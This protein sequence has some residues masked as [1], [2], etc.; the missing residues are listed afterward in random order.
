MSAERVAD[1][2]LL[3]LSSTKRLAALLG[4]AQAASR[5]ILL[6][7]QRTG[8]PWST[9]TVP[10]APTAVAPAP[11]SETATQPLEGIDTVDQQASELV[12]QPRL[13]EPLREGDSPP[14]LPLPLPHLSPLDALGLDGLASGSASSSGNSSGE[15]GGGSSSVEVLEAAQPAAKCHCLRGGDVIG[16]AEARLRRRTYRE[17]LD[18]AYKLPPALSLCGSSDWKTVRGVATWLRPA[19]HGIPVAAP[20]GHEVRIL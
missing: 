6:G 10:S 15:S 18:Y 4:P 3:R 16:V 9:A 19:Q 5:E 13:Q 12:A 20:L 7:V 8:R 2:F 1:L 14:P 11:E 17:P